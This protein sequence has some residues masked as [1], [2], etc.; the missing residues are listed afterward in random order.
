MIKKRLL[1]AAAL[2]ACVAVLTSCTT[3]GAVKTI[4]KV[5]SDELQFQGIKAGDT[6][7]TIKTNMG[8]IK[9]VLYP[10]LAP[11]AV[12]NFTTHA[13][14]GYYNGLTFHRVI[15]GF[16]IQGGDP[17]GDGTGGDSIWGLPFNDEFSDQLH[18]Y[19]GALS[20]ANY[21]KNTNLSQFFIVT[22]RPKDLDPKVVE[23]MKGAG[24][25]ESVI[26]TYKKAGGAPNLDYQHTVFGYVYE[27][28]DVAFAI[29]ESKTDT[30]DKP[31]TDVI[32]ESIEISKAE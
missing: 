27:G 3:K 10:E 25:R 1:T 21:G 28:L 23:L 17:V 30:S 29:S 9:I 22:S 18:N 11:L 26:E 6:I 15:K 32:I 31:K 20:M 19:T 13:K 24:W 5:Q 2:V 14:D 4:E 16:M 7:G 12:E 8:D